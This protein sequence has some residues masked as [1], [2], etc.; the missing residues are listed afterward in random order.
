MNNQNNIIPNYNNDINNYKPNNLNNNNYFNKE[1]ESNTNNNNF[2]NN[3]EPQKKNDIQIQINSK[4]FERIDAIIKKCESL[5]NKAKT[6][7]EN[8]K[9]KESISILKK[10]IATLMSVKQTI[11]TQ[12]KEMSAFIP[13]INMLEYMSTSMLYDFR[14]NIYETIDIKYK[15]INAKQYTQNESLINFCS[16]FIL[17]NPFI[18]FDDIYNNN[19]MIECYI[20]KISE[21]TR[22]NKKCILL[23]GDR[24]SGKT[25]L[26][27]GYANKMGGT[28]AQI[29]NEEF[30][31]IPFFAKEFI[32]ICFKN[33][34][35]NKPMFVYMKNIE[36]MLSSKNQIDFIYDKVASSFNLNVYFIA[37]TNIDL[38]MLHRDIYNKFQYYQEVKTIETKNKADFMRFIC[39]K[40]DIKL[41]VNMY[42]LNNFVNQNLDNFPNKKI[43]ELIKC[44]INLKKQKTNQRDEP[45]WVYKEGLNLLDLKNAI[46]SINPYL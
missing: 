18:S 19:N 37:S 11:I 2:N 22:Y 39:E 7:N 13:Q 34:G 9:I 46:S 4:D 28:V 32:K 12:K 1:Y 26:V 5:Y 30:L 42:E 33:I 44:A 20:D 14:I 25:L 8:Y 45:N 35:M 27:H 40:F 36:N 43:Y 15:S 41:N 38:R 21:A 16:R 17:Y 10:I 6:E 24:G 23:Y 3:F 29:D 31:K